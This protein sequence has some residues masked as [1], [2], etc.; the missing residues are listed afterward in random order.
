MSFSAGQDGHPPADLRGRF[1]GG[2]PGA[3]HM[4]TTTSAGIPIG[5]FSWFTPTRG[6]DCA[7]L[8]ASGLGFRL[9]GRR[10]TPHARGDD[11]GVPAKR[12]RGRARGPPPRP[13]GRRR[14][15][16]LAR[17][18]SRTE[19]FTPTGVGTTKVDANPVPSARLTSAHP[20]ARG[21]RRRFSD[22]R[23]PSGAQITAVHPHARGDRR[24]TLINGLR[25]PG[26]VRFTPHARGDDWWRC[27]PTGSCAPTAHPPRAWGRRSARRPFL[28]GAD[29]FLPPRARGDDGIVPRTWRLTPANRTVPPPRA[30]GRRTAV[31]I[32]ALRRRRH[33]VHPHARTWGRRYSSASKRCVDRLRPVHPHAR[34]DDLIVKVSP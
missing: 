19:R 14:R 16:E 18:R 25:G 21:G 5:R 6:D 23:M 10:F 28:H 13:W 32:H 24:P 3:T 20:H 26:D 8:C 31:R 11:E 2:S 15:L 4:G 17:D 9:R 7:R 12:A 22:G 33:T 29:R 1:S 27:R 30:W 34:G